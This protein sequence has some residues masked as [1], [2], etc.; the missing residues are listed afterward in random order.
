MMKLWKIPVELL[1]FECILETAQSSFFFSLS[2]IFCFAISQWV[3]S[4]IRN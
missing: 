1:K 3:H 2:E 4:R